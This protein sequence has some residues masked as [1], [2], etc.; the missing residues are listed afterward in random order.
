MKIKNILP[1][2]TAAS[3]LLI[4]AQTSAAGFA[5][6]ESGASGL[7]NAYAG[8]AANAEDSSTIWFNPAGMTRL[9]NEMMA[10]AHII[11]VDSAFTD[12]GSTSALGG[13]LD[14][15]NTDRTAGGGKNAIIPNLFWVK[16]I[17]KDLKL[18][19]GINVPFG[20]GTDYDDDWIGRYHAVRSDVM[21][22]N[23]N[24]SI[25]YKTG[26][27]SLGFGIN[28]QY[29]NVELTSAIDL[30]AL[31]QELGFPTSTCTAQGN[32]GFAELDADGWAYGYNFG[33]LYDLNKN[34]RVG[35]SYRSS[36]DHDV[37]GNADFTVPSTL[38]FLTLSG[39]FTDTT[40]TGSV[41]LPASTSISYFQNINEKIAIMADYT[42]TSW[43]SFEELR[44]DYAS[45]QDDTATTQDWRDSARIS[46]GL[47]Y[48][49]SPK[50]LYR[51]GV[52]IDETVISS[53]ELRTAR[54]PGS[55][56]TW[57]AFGVTHQFDKSRSFSL[58]YAH[59]FVDDADINNTYETES[60]VSPATALQ[61][62]LKG[63]Y[64]ANVD[65]IS[66]QVSWEY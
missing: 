62:T 53:N 57:L 59:L 8:G 29:I 34:A 2:V 11:M 47:N 50:W 46:L 35:F 55:D 36:M 1:V 48:R 22:L 7:G 15:T 26:N 39:D 58:G 27:T 23:I 45:Q 18:G 21:T 56:R 44:I 66:A 41:S 24:P 64:N 28:A 37:E 5:I 19:L 14:P 38:D 20:L 6:I 49:Y 43:S 65:I 25:A 52:A 42:L 12:T 54:T 32:D 9:D 10:A 40:L 61:H 17:H 4:S 3:M 30:G 63:T 16:E 31:C 51:M 33:I 13:D 60:Q